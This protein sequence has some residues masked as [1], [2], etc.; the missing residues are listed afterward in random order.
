MRESARERKTNVTDIQVAVNLDGTGVHKI[1]TGVGFFDHMLAQ[2][3][4][5]AGMDLVV[6]SRGDLNIDAHHTVEDTGLVLGDALKEALGERRDIMRYGTSIVPTD[7]A[8]VMTSIDLGG[9]A[10][11]VFNANLEDTS[12]GQFDTALC[13]EFFR[14]V[15]ERGSFTLHIN[16]F[17]GKNLHH[18]IESIFKSFGHALRDAATLDPGSGIMSV[19]GTF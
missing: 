7:D 16:Q 8:L 17:Y 14:S 15:C 1:S 18:I 12:I 10:F 2:V 5:H 3:A 11:L 19:K 9:R 4:V 13:S 6:R